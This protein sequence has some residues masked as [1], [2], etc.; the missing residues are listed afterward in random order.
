MNMVWQ[1]DHGIACY[2]MLFGYGRIDRAQKADLI[3]ERRRRPVCERD[4]EEIR[5]TRNIKATIAPLG[6]QNDDKA[7]AQH[8]KQRRGVPLAEMAKA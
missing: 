6:L 7:K 1:D 5:S 3:H 4:G 2:W 8:R